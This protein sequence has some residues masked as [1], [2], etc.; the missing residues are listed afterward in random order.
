MQLRRPL[1]R[2]IER[3]HPWIYDQAVG[4]V[5]GDAGEVVSIADERGAFATAFVEPGAPIRARVLVREAGA[6]V[7]AD[8]ARASARVAAGHRGIP[9]ELRETDALRAI[10][11]ENDGLPGLTVDVYAGVAVVVFDGPAA[12]AFWRPRMDAVIAGVREGGI[13]VTAVWTRGQRRSGTGAGTG[14]GTVAERVMMRE[15]GARFGVDVRAGQKTGFFLDQRA[16]RAR[17]AELA[18]GARLLNLCSY[19]GGFSV[20]AGLG[21]AA[22]V[23]SV[24]LAAPAIAD[25]ERHWRENGLAS[26]RHAGV[27]ADAF[28]FLELARSKRER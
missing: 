13:E 7:G 3:G 8:W 2:A 22:H 28:E 25:A 12:A 14:T 16:N 23:T 27:V 18:R 15:G 10:H 20:Q 19:S 4:N 24:D 26:G 9:V 5:S 11:G 1:R 6:E 21:G 17:V